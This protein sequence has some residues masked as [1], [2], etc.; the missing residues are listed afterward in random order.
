MTNDDNIIADL[1]KK[2]DSLQATINTQ[3]A[4]IMKMATYRDD[5][6]DKLESERTKR[7]GELMAIARDVDFVGIFSRWLLDKEQASRRPPYSAGRPDSEETKP[8][9]LDS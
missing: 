4:F 1:L 9:D 5:R 6:E 7:L 8:E 2:I 3:N